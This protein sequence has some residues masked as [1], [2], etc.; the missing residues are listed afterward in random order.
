MEVRFAIVIYCK[1]LDFE[2]NIIYYS[3]INNSSSALYV[4][5]L[6]RIYINNCNFSYCVTSNKGVIEMENPRLKTTTTISKCIFLNCLS[7]Q[8]IIELI[9]G[10]TEI[11][12]CSFLFDNEVVEEFLLE[13]Q[14][15]LFK[16][17]NLLKQILMEL[18]FIISN[19]IV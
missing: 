10:I 13:N 6:E 16:T 1:E 9:Y 12:S 19:Q 15:F 3:N 11:D 18:L 5:N 14:F 8:Y 2:D 7:R 17:V 4:N